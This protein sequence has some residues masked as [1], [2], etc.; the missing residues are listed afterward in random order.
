MQARLHS[1]AARRAQ[2]RA[3]QA[4]ERARAEAMAEASKAEPVESIL[5]V[6]QAL[7]GLLDK[8]AEL[9][10]DE[11]G[12]E[13]YDEAFDRASLSQDRNELVALRD[14]LTELSTPEAGRRRALI[15]DFGNKAIDAMAKVLGIEVKKG[16]L[17]ERRPLLSKAAV[18]WETFKEASS[19]VASHDD[20]DEALAKVIEDDETNETKA[21]NGVATDEG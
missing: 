11:M 6:Q 15:A 16:K 2:R 5:E 19:L 9:L 4:A 21:T 8:Q 20:A 13:A 10:E 17:D 12:L 18:P 7:L 1:V 14:R 3:A